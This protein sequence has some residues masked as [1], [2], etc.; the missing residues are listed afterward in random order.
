MVKFPLV[1]VSFIYIN[2]Y[3]YR[4]R[5]WKGDCGFMHAYFFALDSNIFRKK[6]FQEIT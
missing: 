6:S 1:N 2:T 5:Q 4:Y 3:I